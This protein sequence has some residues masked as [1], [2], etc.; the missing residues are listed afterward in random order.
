MQHEIVNT[1]HL[2]ASCRPHAGP[3]REIDTRNPSEISR[4]S[5]E[6]GVTWLQL[7]RII[8]RVGTNVRAVRSAVLKQHGVIWH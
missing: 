5:R 1:R 7:F 6:L 4:L 2:V 8:D 3:R